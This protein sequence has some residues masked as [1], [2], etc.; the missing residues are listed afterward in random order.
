[1]TPSGTGVLM[2]RRYSGCKLRNA[3]KIISPPVRLRTRGFSRELRSRFPGKIVHGQVKYFDWYFAELSALIY[4]FRLVL[5]AQI[6]ESL[7]N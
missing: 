3:P 7:C 6:I 2:S 5:S 1:M 4:T